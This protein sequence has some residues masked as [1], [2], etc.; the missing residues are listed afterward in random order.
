M[1]DI[2]VEA[3]GRINFAQ[4][5]IDRKGITNRVTLNG[6]TLTN[7][8]TY[9][10]PMDEK[11]ITSLDLTP[12]P[13]PKE[14]GGERPKF[15]SGNFNL[16]DVADTYLDMRNYKKS[17]VWVNGNNLGRYWNKGP[18][19]RLYC[20]AIFLRKGKNEI[21]VFDLHQQNGADIKGVKTLE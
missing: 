11:F 3:M 10:L 4:Y 13:S 1:L 19:F 8:Q 15:F 7:W 14:S 20:P 17:V 18:Q 2:F 6:I 16:N 9:C 21:I 5:L 12:D